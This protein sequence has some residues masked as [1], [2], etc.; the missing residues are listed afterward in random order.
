[1][2]PCCRINADFKYKGLGQYSSSSESPKHAENEQE[3]FLSLARQS[4]YVEVMNWSLNLHSQLAS[5]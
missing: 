4:P 5:T 3:A 2:P 1:M